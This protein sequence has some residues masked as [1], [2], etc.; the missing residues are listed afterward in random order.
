MVQPAPRNGERMM[1]TRRLWQSTREI[2][3]QRSQGIITADEAMREIERA[4][5][6]YS[7]GAEQLKMNLT[8]KEG[9]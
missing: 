3:W 6:A 8:T 1:D 2:L 5:I 4:V 9:A 7:E